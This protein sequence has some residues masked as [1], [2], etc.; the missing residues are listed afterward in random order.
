MEEYKKSNPLAML[1]SALEMCSALRLCLLLGIAGVSEH[2]L[3][4]PFFASAMLR[5]ACE[6]KQATSTYRYVD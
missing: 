6:P 1:K 4:S 3:D 5:L 2:F